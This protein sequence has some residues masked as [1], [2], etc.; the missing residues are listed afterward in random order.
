V[1]EQT[2][3]A[4]V[5]SWEY[6]V[7]IVSGLLT[8]ATAS[9]AVFAYRAY[10]WHARHRETQLSGDL[11]ELHRT[12]V[13]GSQHERLSQIASLAGVVLSL[14]ALVA[15]GGFTRRSHQLSDLQ[16]DSRT[17]LAHT[18]QGAA[19]KAGQAVN[20]LDR[21]KSRLAATETELGKTED[22][23]K[24]A[25]TE[26]AKAKTRLHILENDRVPRTLTKKQ[27]DTL[28]ALLKPEAPQELFIFR[29]PDQE[30]VSYAT[31]IQAILGE[32][33]WKVV[34][35]PRNAGTITSFPD[36]LELLVADVAK[37]VSRG[38][39]KLQES[40]ERIGL[41]MPA[42]PLLLIPEGKFALYVGPKPKFVANLKTSTN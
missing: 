32:A 17:K 3:Q 13:K 40:F 26:L 30:S 5:S 2:L 29:A 37:P 41:R 16:N 1:S 11:H 9:A 25:Y 18:A 27:K 15:T 4:A 42:A 12:D 33:G 7:L 36:G 8:V 22:D 35:Y 39:F 6:F 28:L 10:V 20:D 21:A 23:L 24:N 14:L 38:A 19:E 31:A 34:E